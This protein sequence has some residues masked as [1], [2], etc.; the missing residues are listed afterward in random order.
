MSPSCPCN[1]DRMQHRWILALGLVAA[2]CGA[3]HAPTA[4]TAPVA[5]KARDPLRKPIGHLS[6]HVLDRATGA[7]LAGVTVIAMSPAMEG[8]QTEVTDAEGA[9]FLYVVGPGTY[10]LTFHYAD[11]EDRK[12][13][14]AVGSDDTT[15]DERLP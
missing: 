9:Y 1:D 14:I 6:G 7:P 11:R 13:G 8:A 3:T 12:D 2:G 10:S 15:F 4:P 5:S